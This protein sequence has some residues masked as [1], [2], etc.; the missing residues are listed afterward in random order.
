M[1]ISDWSSD[2]CSSDLLCQC[3]ARDGIGAF[4]DEQSSIFQGDL[5]HEL[6]FFSVVL[7]VALFAADLDLVQG[8][9]CNIYMT[10]FDQFRHLAI[11]QGQQQ[12]TDMRAI[13]RKS[14]V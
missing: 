12:G 8:W 11:Q 4:L 2:V 10:A 1:R 9:L 13:D 5:Q 7:Q 3:I 6:R 14:V